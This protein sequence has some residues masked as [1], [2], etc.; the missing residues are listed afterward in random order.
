MENQNTFIVPIWD[1][2]PDTQEQIEIQ[3]ER[4]TALIEE[5]WF[6]LDSSS[7]LCLNKIMQ[8]EFLRLIQHLTESKIIQLGE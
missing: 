2:V 1:S 7:A 4:L 5:Q 8:D 6:I 3:I